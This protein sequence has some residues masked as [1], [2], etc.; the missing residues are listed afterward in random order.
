M[1]K[2]IFIKNFFNLIINQGINIFI[3]LL[4]TRVLF[5][6]L[7]EA[8]FGLVNLALSV[9]L[10]S[11]IAVS[12][13]YHLNGPKRIALFRGESAKKQSLI[14]EI[15][16]TRIIIATGMAII[17]FCLTYFFGFF[18]SYAALLYYS[19]ILLFSQA[20][21]PMFYFQ[22][23][24]KIAWASLVNA[25]AKGAYLLLIILFIKTPDDAT[26]V[27]FLFG[28]SALVVYIAFW[29]IIYKK[30]K[31]KW[32]WVSIY[33]IKNRF[34]ENFQFFISSIAGHV[35]IH[36]GL[37]ILANFVNN[38]VLGEFALA[39]KIALLMR[40]VPIFFTQAIL[41]KASILFKS[42]K[43][44]FNSYV[45]RIFIIGLTI[46]FAMGLIVIIFS[47]WIIFLLAGSHVVYSDTILKILAFIPFFSMLNFNNM[48]KI[49]VD[50]KKH[51]LTKATWITAIIMLILATTGSYYY[52]GYGLSIALV[53]TE[54]VSF[55]V[56]SVL[57]IK[58][59]NER[60]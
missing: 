25:F 4:A 3:A 29:I 40:M 32:V 42:D 26:Y 41:Q 57:L 23:N 48:I 9:V 51:L 30:E 28:L 16:L 27:N 39:Q 34:I 31:I 37:I 44:E 55:I 20:L 17:L 10:L 15:I 22:G 14:N 18:K 47:K 21:F 60:V 2:G 1:F 33:N 7:G 43:I 50:E 54:I 36:G 52:G 35:S 6:T 5:S 11:S 45:N 24:D 53:L 8:Q 59:N 38:T 49:L 13:G 56:H 46:T 12:Y 58:N 19:L